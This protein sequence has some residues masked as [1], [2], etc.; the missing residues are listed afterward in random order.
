MLAYGT[1]VHVAAAAAEETGIDAEIIDLRTLVP[2]D[3]ETIVASVSK[4]G[5]CVVA[6]E[7]TLTS[8]FGAELCAAIQEELLVPPGGADHRVTGWDTPV[9]P[10]PRVALL[11]R[12]PTPRRGDEGHVGGLAMAVRVVRAARRRRGRGR[13]RAGQLAGGRRRRRP[14]GLGARRGAHRQGDGRGVLPRRRAGDVPGAARSARCSP[15]AATS[16]ASRPTPP[17]TLPAAAAPT[18]HRP[19]RAS[20][21]SADGSTAASSPTA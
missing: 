20:R 18:R 10:R 8:G 9:P 13:G 1:L 7:A 17:P 6:H 5:R 11:P 15:S 2:L 3:F 16:S 4:T 19:S 14:P 12:P 21:V